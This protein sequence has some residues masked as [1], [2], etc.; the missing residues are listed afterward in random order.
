M[1]WPAPIETPGI[2][3]DRGPVL[4]TIQYRIHPSNRD[5]FLIALGRLSRERRRD[6]AYAWDVF[7]DVAA[8]GR[9]VETFYVGSW[10]EH[11]R[12]HRRVTNSD[13]LLQDDVLRFQTE[14]TPEITHFVSAKPGMK[15]PPDP[16]GG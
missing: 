1:H 6:G 16:A 3:Y 8:P 7:E 10:L 15:V 12:Q 4:V 5:A 9:M 14:G 11:L 13:R 2:E